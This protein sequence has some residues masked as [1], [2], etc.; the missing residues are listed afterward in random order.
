MTP[1]HSICSIYIKVLKLPKTNGEAQAVD[2][3]VVEETMVFIRIL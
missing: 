3:S 1:Y 2:K